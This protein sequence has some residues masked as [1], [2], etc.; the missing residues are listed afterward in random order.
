MWLGANDVTEEGIFTWSSTGNP[1]TTYY[2]WKEGEPSNQNGES[3]D[4][5]CVEMIVDSGQWND[6][7]CN[8]Q[9]FST[10]CEKILSSR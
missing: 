9:I 10:M 3:N 8:W 1:L 2:N 4:E 7:V 5:D 6:V